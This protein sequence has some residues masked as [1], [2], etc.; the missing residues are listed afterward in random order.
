M[1]GAYYNEI[2][3]FAA[4]WLRELIAAGHIAPGVVDERSI[5]EIEAGDL[6]GY[7]QVHFFAGIG[8]W[9][10]ALRLAGWSDDRPVWTGSCPCQPFS[11]AGKGKG[12]D[13]RR[14]LWPHFYRL[15]RE[16]KPAT[17][18]GEQVAGKAG[19][20]WFDAVSADL[21]AA[22]YAVGAADLGAC[23]VGAPHKRQRLY[24]VADSQSD[25]C[26][27]ESAHHRGGHEGDRT[28]GVSAGP[29]S[30][31]EVGKLADSNDQG[32][33]GQEGGRVGPKERSSG[34]SSLG[35]QG[36]GPTGGF[37]ADCDWLFC[38]D[39]KWRPVE[40]GS[41]P[42]VDGTPNRV[43]R[44]RGYGNAIVAPLAAEFI[45]AFL[46]GPKLG[47]HCRNI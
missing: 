27:E 1:K 14:H 44:L 23:G 36:S 25:G 6:E 2:D 43:G 26:G 4:G 37:W 7:S 35:R 21:E 33:Q 31:G 32:L 20:T 34:A 3:P 10:Y 12:F 46:D 22:G 5:E 9:S 29:N 13:D 38:R 47:A 45:G 11:S 42:L 19:F 39:E 30:S 41:F 8:V 24:F 17:I 15:I 40:P 28:K 18:F 16:C